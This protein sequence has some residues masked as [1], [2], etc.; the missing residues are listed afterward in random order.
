MKQV[1]VVA[2]HPDDET[3]GCA[4]TLLKL[5]SKGY[6]LHW[7]I[8]TCVDSALSAVD[9]SCLQKRQA[10]IAKVRRLYPFHEVHPFSIPTTHVGEMAFS[11]LV[12]KFSDLFHMVKPQILFLP[13]CNDVHSDHYFVAKAV[14]SCCKWFRHPEIEFVF[15]YETLSET[16]FNINIA[17]MPFRPNLYV[18]IAT[19]WNRKMEILQVYQSELG[20]FPFPRSMQAVQAL[21]Q[22]RGSECG[23]HFA[24]AFQLIRGVW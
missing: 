12:Q 2:P 9:A 15:Y 3:L 19:F 13:F 24:E 16:N 23:A 14:L 7:G 11:L 10:E 8:A 20:E 5:C 6:V 17:D 22:L 4:G 21:A 18:D 1:L